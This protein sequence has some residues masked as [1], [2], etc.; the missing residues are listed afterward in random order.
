M[1]AMLILKMVKYSK[2]TCDKFHKNVSNS[3]NM[4]FLMQI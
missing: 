3:I 4:V 1:G 2:K